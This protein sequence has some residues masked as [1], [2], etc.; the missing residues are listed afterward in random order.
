MSA[1]EEGFELSWQSFSLTCNG[2]EFLGIT[3]CKYQQKVTREMVY[4]ASPNAIG[5]TEGKVENEEASITFLELELREFIASLGQNY[6]RKPFQLVG[7]YGAPGTPVYTDILERCMLGG[8]GE[9][10]GEEGTDA[11]KR[12]VPFTFMRLKRN[13]L[14]IINNRRR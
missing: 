10:G 4:G 2:R 9:G 11:F 3:G 8:D 14:Y 1:S 13:G 5:R 7:Q 6:G 12:E